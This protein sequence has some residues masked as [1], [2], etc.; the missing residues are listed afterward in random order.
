LT[1]KKSKKC[2]QVLRCAVCQY[3]E[4]RNPIIMT[5]TTPSKVW[6]AL[7][8]K[9]CGMKTP[10]GPFQSQNMNMN[11]IVNE[12]RSWSAHYHLLRSLTFSAPSAPT[13]RP[14]A[15]RTRMKPTTI[16]Y[17]NSAPTA[18]AQ[19]PVPF[20]MKGRF[21]YYSEIQHSERRKDWTPGLRDGSMS[22]MQSLICHR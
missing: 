13:T 20:Q 4:S 2:E 6:G 19:N 16:R 14:W 9:N 22:A 15:R 7:C 17:I 8:I 1:Y 11:F 3:I 10:S 5:T 12:A 21:I 18:Y